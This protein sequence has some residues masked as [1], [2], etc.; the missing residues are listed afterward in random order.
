MLRLSSLAR[1]RSG[2]TAVEYAMVAL[3]IS[4]AVVV[5]IGTIGGSVNG[6]FQ[7]IASNL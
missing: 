2:A 4:L 7:D 3:F 1:A 6:F 5:V